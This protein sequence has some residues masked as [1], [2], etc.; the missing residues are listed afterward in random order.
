M[1]K[2]GITHKGK[3]LQSFRDFLTMAQVI[4]AD[5]ASDSSVRTS[6]TVGFQKNWTM[7]RDSKV[8]NPPTFRNVPRM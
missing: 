8:A 5:K 6:A 7:K 2:E 4:Y 3:T 1:N